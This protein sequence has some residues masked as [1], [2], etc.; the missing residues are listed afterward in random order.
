MCVIVA[1]LNSF[2]I[3]QDPCLHTLYGDDIGGHYGYS[4]EALPAYIVAT[5]FGPLVGFLSS[6]KEIKDS[7]K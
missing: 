6:L 2:E 3:I 5:S 7:T 4:T 1:K